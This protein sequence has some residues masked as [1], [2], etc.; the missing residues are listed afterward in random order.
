ML[1]K[2][3]KHGLVERLIIVAESEVSYLDPVKYGSSD[4]TGI[5]SPVGG[6]GQGEGGAKK[7]HYCRVQL[8]EG[9]GL[10]G[11]E[12]EFGNAMSGMALESVGNVN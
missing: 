11:G 7:R 5:F 1:H 6:Q 10:E 8:K 9:V 2:Y 12:Y 4:K 3:L